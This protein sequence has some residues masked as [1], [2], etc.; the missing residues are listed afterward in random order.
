MKQKKDTP[1]KNYKRKAIYYLIFLFSFL[2]IVFLFMIINWNNEAEITEEETSPTN[3]NLFPTI[4]PNSSLQSNDI[5]GT[6]TSSCSSFSFP[7]C[8]LVSWFVW[9]FMTLMLFKFIFG[10]RRRLIFC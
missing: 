5:H 6:T 8:D 3:T 9:I 1:K 2:L 4:I 10:R 7:P